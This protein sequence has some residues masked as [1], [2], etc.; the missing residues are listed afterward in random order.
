M[1]EKDAFRGTT[2]VGIVTKDAL[3]FAAERKVT[4]GHMDLSET[5]RIFKLDDTIAITTSGLLGDLQAIVRI[6]TANVNL[7]KLEKGSVSVRAV[8]KFTA[9]F[10]HQRKMFPYLT[11]LLI[12]GVDEK[13]ELYTLDI[14]GGTSIEDSF[15]A[16]GSGL[17]F[18]YGVLEA[19]YKESL[20][21]EDAQNLALRALKSAIRRDVTSGGT[22]DIITITKKGFETKE[23]PQALPA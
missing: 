21:I 20:S 18:A 23:I 7:I 8:A 3:I 4:Y 19:H 1:D 13:P 5:P 12:G 2:T 14:V 22:I 15:A 17:T 6:L 10:L 16:T 9:N 11:E